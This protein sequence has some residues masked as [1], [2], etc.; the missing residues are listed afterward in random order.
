MAKT[1]HHS[2]ARRVNFL[3]KGSISIH[4]PGGMALSNPDIQRL[5]ADGHMKL[6]RNAWKG[7]YGYSLSR[8]VVVITDSG[9]AFL[10]RHMNF[11]HDAPP[12]RDS[13]KYEAYWIGRKK[14]AGR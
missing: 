1:K 14:P 4:C 13:R 3:N 10:A 9:R 6:A 7:C 8:S 12:P 11:V 5:L 2:L